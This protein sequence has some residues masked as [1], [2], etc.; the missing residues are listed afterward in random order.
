MHTGYG[1]QKI[2]GMDTDQSHYPSCYPKHIGTQS[3]C[4]RPFLC[5]FYHILLVAT[6][7]TFATLATLGSIGIIVIHGILITYCE[8]V[9]TKHCNEFR[10]AA[11]AQLLNLSPQRKIRRIIW[12]LPFF[13]PMQ[14]IS[15]SNTFPSN[16][17]KKRFFLASFS[18]PE[19]ER[20]VSTICH[21][22]FSGTLLPYFSKQ[23]ST[24]SAQLRTKSISSLLRDLRG[25]DPIAVRARQFP[26][27]DNV[28]KLTQYQAVARALPVPRN[29]PKLPGVLLTTSITSFTQGVSSIE[30]IP[31]YVHG[32][33]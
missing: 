17:R 12:V 23:E 29:I 19:G 21:P 32:N 26:S 5:I 10:I 33:K 25:I 11:V 13:S 28:L 14:F 24:V 31:S 8:K 16:V 30:E 22:R 20:K 1:S 27:S 4:R 15:A 3:C 2:T 6:L 9:H 7:A 18:S